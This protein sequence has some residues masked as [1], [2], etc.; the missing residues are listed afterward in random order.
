MKD[1][2]LVGGVSLLQAILYTA[3]AL[4]LALW[5]CFCRLQRA[6]STTG[7][8]QALFLALFGSSGCYCCRLFA[9]SL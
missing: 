7:S 9:A 2:V 8:G 6:L 3:T 5:T 4:A 1:W